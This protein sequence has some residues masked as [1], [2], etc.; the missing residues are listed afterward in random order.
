MTL[1]AI[2]ITP[3]SGSASTIAPGATIE[4]TDTATGPSGSPLAGAKLTFTVAPTW[5]GTV[6]GAATTTWAGVAYWN[7]TAPSTL[8]AWAH[9]N[10]TA[11]ATAAGYKQGSASAQPF[12]VESPASTSPSPS[13]N[14]SNSGL[15]GN[16]LLL[17][18]IIGVVV[19]VIAVLALL[20]MRKKK[21]VGAAPQAWSGPAPAE[22]SEGMAPPPEGGAPPESG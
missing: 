1:S 14:N 18:A 6:P 22:G 7:L 19:V 13:N 16:P 8:T 5:S 9:Y 17:A 11:T 10:I 3:S 2:T 21:G 4:F 15:L 20:M 12:V